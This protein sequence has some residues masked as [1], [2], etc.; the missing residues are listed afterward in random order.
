MRQTLLNLLPGLLLL[1]AA[2]LWAA[3]APSSVVWNTP[4]DQVSADVH[5]EALWPLLE[6]IAHQ[7]G[8]HVFV[9]PDTDRNVDVKFTNLASG[10]ALRKLLGDL[11]FAFVPKTNEASQLYVFRTRME[12]A[13][14]RVL[15]THTVA[16]SRPQKHVPNQLVVKLKPGADIDALAKS[17][18]AKVVGR[19]D[20]LGIYLLEFP[21]AAATDAALADL[22]GN[23]AVA[24]V[25]YD[26]IYD[27]PPAPQ[28]F[29][30][31]SGAPPSL[32]L[33]PTSSGDP[34]NPVIGLIDT[35][36]QPSGTA[37][38]Q[39][40]LKPI[41]VV[42]N[43]GASSLGITHATAMYQTI[44]NAISQ[45]SGGHTGAK[46]L[47]VQVFDD[48]ES[49]STWNVALGVQAAVN[50]GATVLNMSLGGTSDSPVLD[51]IIQQAVAKGIVVFAAAGNQPVSTPTYPAAL[52]G[53]NSVTALSAPGQLASYANFGS[54]SSLALPGTS[55]VYQ[56]GL[57]WVVQGTSPATANATGVAVGTKSVNCAGWS[58]IIN[59]MQAKFQ[60]P[61]KN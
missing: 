14:R 26:Y 13:T 36:I 55:V 56:G 2:P 24:A 42:G 40:M 54:F 60:V 39:F 22:K 52:P 44:L 4:A 48:S 57:G 8:W 37:L 18:G 25:E 47:P 27:A 41:S 34:C 19:D 29:P 31:A 32:T 3:G 10:D 1:V 20:K 11:N 6:D 15:V 7:T 5:D 28:V 45:S 59:A 61:A 16:K 23:S 17:I 51:D 30:N 58:Q 9:E 35:A 46:I 38:D 50:N 49:A 12:N 21:D 33:D 53:V 43:A